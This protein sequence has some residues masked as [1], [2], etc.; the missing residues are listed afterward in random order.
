MPEYWVVDPSLRSI[1][2][3]AFV[4][5]AYELIQCAGSHDDVASRVRPDLALR[6]ADVFP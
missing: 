2:V 6:A 3:Y 5:S 4:G 1:E